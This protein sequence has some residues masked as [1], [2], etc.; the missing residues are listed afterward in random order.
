MQPLLLVFMSLLAIWPATQQPSSWREYTSS[1]GRFT[2]TLPANVNTNL[3]AIDTSKSRL[4]T[5]MVSATDADL[6]E[7]MVSWT[8][9]PD[10]KS[11]PRDTEKSLNR[12]RDALVKFKKGTIVSESPISFASHTG[13]EIA[14]TT[15]EGRLVRV[16]F[17]FVDNRIYQ[18]VAET[19]KDKFRVNERE[20]PGVVDRF[21]D[22]FKLLSGTP[23]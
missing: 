12:M 21:F 5:H 16:R 18:L 19:W 22:S 6:N 20:D 14:F 10:D 3:M 9:Y 11:R 7:Y 13:R 15:D 17:Y 1:E 2:A 23:V 4:F 8:E